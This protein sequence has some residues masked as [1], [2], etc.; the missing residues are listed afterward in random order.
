ME[1]RLNLERQLREE[2]EKLHLMRLD[3]RD[4]ENRVTQKEMVRLG[5]LGTGTDMVSNGMITLDKIGNLILTKLL[6]IFL[7]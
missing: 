5:P 7:L 6:H 2:R 1:Q 4:L 3:I